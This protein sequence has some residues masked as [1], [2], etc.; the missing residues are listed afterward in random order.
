MLINYFGELYLNMAKEYK[1][2]MIQAELSFMDACMYIKHGMHL[3]SNAAAAKGRIA[4]A[5]GLPK[6]VSYKEYAFYLGVTL[7]DGGRKKF[8]IDYMRKHG[9]VAAT[10]KGKNVLKVKK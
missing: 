5:M 7:I 8:V 2:P 9:F 4:Q 3:S 6:G 1:I 10:E